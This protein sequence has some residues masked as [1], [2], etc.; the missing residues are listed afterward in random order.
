MDP[1]G[2]EAVRPLWEKLRLYHATLLDDRPPFL[3]EPRKQEILGKAAAGRLRIE[4][5]G[6]GSHAVDI[7]Y[8]ISTANAAGCGEVDSLFV[9]EQFRRCGVGSELLRRALA[10]LED[11]G[12]SSTVVTVAYA[13]QGALALYKRFGFYPHKIFLQQ[14]RQNVGRCSLES[15][16]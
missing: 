7:A 3:F 5:A 8:C 9:E 15:H 16:E 10:W 4:L 11:V 13:N 14:S 6:I 2:I 12:T 1:V